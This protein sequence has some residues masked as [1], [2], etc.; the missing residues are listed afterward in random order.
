VEAKTLQHP[1]EIMSDHDEI[2]AFIS[3]EQGTPIVD[4]SGNKHER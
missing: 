2:E 3:L 4:R 1:P